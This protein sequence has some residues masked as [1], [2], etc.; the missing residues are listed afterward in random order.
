MSVRSAVRPFVVGALCLI[1]TGCATTSGGGSSRS[2]SEL[3]ADEIAQLQV[4]NAFQAVERAR[5]QWLNA[6]ASP[7]PTNPDG[8]QP[9]VYIDGIRAGGL[10]E[11]RRVRVQVVRRIEYIRASDATTQFGTNHGGGAILVTTR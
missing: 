5:P 10:E 2:S 4:V 9:V 6:R 7:T 3:L 1:A 8:A 11:L